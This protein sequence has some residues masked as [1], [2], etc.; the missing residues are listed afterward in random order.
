M[1]YYR[2]IFHL[3][4]YF[5]PLTYMIVPLDRAGQSITDGNTNGRP[6]PPVKRTIDLRVGDEILSDGQWMRITAIEPWRE[7]WL[8]EESAA[9]RDVG[10]GYGYLYR[11][12]LQPVE[13]PTASGAGSKWHVVYAEDSNPSGVSAE[14]SG[15][16]G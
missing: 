4:F 5:G 6:R 11:P 16:S 3:K 12:K 14:A 7:W 9:D 10:N 1:A 8:A 2:L 13:P 15:P